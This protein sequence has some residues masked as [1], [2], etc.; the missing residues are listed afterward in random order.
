MDFHKHLLN[1]GNAVG[2]PVPRYVTVMGG[3]RSGTNYLRY[4]LEENY[5]CTAGYD[6]YGW[7]HAG[8][9]IRPRRRRTAFLRPPVISIAKNPFAHLVSLHKYFVERGRNIHASREW[10]A[11]LREPF[12]IFNQ[13]ETHSPQYHFASPAHYWNFVN[14]NLAFLPAQTVPSF[15][16]TYDD[17][18]REPATQI[19]NAAQAL[20]LRRKSGEFRTPQGYMR[21]LG[22]KSYRAEDMVLQDQ[23][24]PEET[25]ITEKRYLEPFTDAQ[26]R[27]VVSQLDPRLLDRLGLAGDEYR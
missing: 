4:L 27:L 16:V 23:K 24:P 26:R 9:P 14:W 11:F 25:Y 22:D 13:S 21:R 3:F 8:V 5:H 6:A 18:L 17:V 2:L 1:V 7:K 19:A 20:G 15:I 10:D 12:V